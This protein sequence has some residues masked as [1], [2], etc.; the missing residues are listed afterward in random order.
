MAKEFKTTPKE[1]RAATWFFKAEIY[2]ELVEVVRI[3]GIPIGKTPRQLHIAN[4][5]T[6]YVEKHCPD[7]CIS[8]IEN[9][10]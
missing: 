8:E 3:L 4:K 1:D 7:D 6:Q 10:E 9:Q 2:E 5:I